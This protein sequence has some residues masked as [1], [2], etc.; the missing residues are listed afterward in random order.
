MS[1]KAASLLL[2]LG[3]SVHGSM[4]NKPSA[5]GEA[6]RDPEP[7]DVTLAEVDTN[8]LTGREKAEWSGYVGELLAPCSDVPV[9]IAQCVQEKRNCNKCI[10]AAKMIMRAV[11]DGYA[12]EQVE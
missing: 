6:S 1:A 12:K 2:F 4:C 10:P 3:L 8:T 5:G 9:S 7:V 11:R